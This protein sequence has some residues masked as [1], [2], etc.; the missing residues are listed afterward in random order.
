MKAPTFTLNNQEGKSIALP[1][2]GIIVLYFYPK[3][4]TPG[5]T[6]QACNIRD[7]YDA[8]QKKNI[9][10]FGISGDNEQS[11]QKFKEKYA[12]PFDLLVDT[13]ND[14]AK[15]YGAFGKK[16]MFGIKYEGVLR[17]TIIIK[18]G[19]IHETIKKVDVSNHA[20]QI[21]DALN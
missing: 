12:L 7:E 11:H 2:K 10:I 20:A 9:K 18:D 19:N 17:T 8:L 3:D 6:K 1:K 15:A 4:S 13:N 5:C 21:M 16:N 14:V